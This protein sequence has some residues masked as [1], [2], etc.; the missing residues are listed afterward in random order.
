M[1]C[2]KR[3]QDA[4][5]FASASST[6]HD[7]KVIQDGELSINGP[8]GRK[9]SVRVVPDIPPIVASLEGIDSDALGVMTLPFSAGDDYGVESGEAWITLDL[10]GAPRRHGLSVP[11]E[12]RPELTVSLP[13]PVVGDRSGFEENLVED[14]SKHPWANLPVVLN[15]TVLDAAEQQSRSEPSALLL[16]GRRFFDPMAAAIIEQRRDLLWSR[17]NAQRISQILRAISHPSGRRIS[18]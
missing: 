13:M 12:A 15:L 11:P 5:L 17:A 14:F 6:A 1:R 18:Q 2:L 16:P 10:D 8:N 9:W 4:T 3:Y 7:F